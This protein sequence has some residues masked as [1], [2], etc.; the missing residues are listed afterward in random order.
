MVS[1]SIP[2][3]KLLP[4]VP[5]LVFLMMRWTCKPSKPFP[6]QIALVFCHSNRS[7]LKQLP[8]QRPS[9][10]G[11]T[12]LSILSILTLAN[13][14]TRC[15]I[16]HIT[17]RTLVPKTSGTLYLKLYTWGWWP[18]GAPWHIIHHSQGERIRVVWQ[19]GNILEFTFGVQSLLMCIAFSSLQSI[20]K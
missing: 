15:W 3:S 9:F 18:D 13:F 14:I 12:R 7:E 16:S 1:S 19:P 8:T 4:W 20:N 10:L 2:A 11:L 6:P 17:Y 5:E